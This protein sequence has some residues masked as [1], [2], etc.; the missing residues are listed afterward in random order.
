[1]F[2]KDADLDPLS[3]EFTSRF[4]SEPSEYIY[5]Q[6]DFRAAQRFQVYYEVKDGK[7]LEPVGRIH[8]VAR[9]GSTKDPCSAAITTVGNVITNGS[10]LAAE[11]D[12]QQT[13]AIYLAAGNTEVHQV[14]G[15]RVGPLARAIDTYLTD[16]INSIETC[17]TSIGLICYGSINSTTPY[18]W[19]RLR[20][21]PNGQLL[22][23]VFEQDVSLFSMPFW[24]RFR[25]PGDIER[26]GDFANQAGT[27]LF[28]FIDKRND[29]RYRPPSGAR[30]INP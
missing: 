12:E 8:T 14:A 3:N 22:A 25:N 27:S 30:R 2:S 26:R 6:K 20:Y 1:M 11:N 4:G 16:R 28:P 24:I 5:G 13:G 21:G 17:R 9:V 7:I 23:P 15:G 29:Y 18:I 19:N 10:L